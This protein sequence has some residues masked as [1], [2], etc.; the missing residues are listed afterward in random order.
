MGRIKGLFNMSRWMDNGGI[1]SFATGTG[2]AQSTVQTLKVPSS[3][4]ELVAIRGNLLNTAPAVAESMAGVFSISG[5]DSKIGMYEF[6]SEVGGSKLAAINGTPYT[7]EARWWPVNQRVT[8]NSELGF[9]IEML[10]ALAGNG[11]CTVDCL[12]SNIEQP[13]EAFPPINRRCSR[14][15]STASSTGEQITLS[16]ARKITG[17]SFAVAGSTIAAD[18]SFSAQITLN[19][20]NLDITQTVVQNVE[21]HSIE[22]T[23]GQA[24]AYLK[25]VNV[26]LDVS[27]TMESSVTFSAS[28]NEEVALTNAGFWAYAVEYIPTRPKF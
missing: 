14:E 27:A 11:S 9:S 15:T 7:H 28:L 3:A 24:V 20:G 19:S 4:R 13:A 10:D 16:G 17:F 5:K 22:A 2:T 8:P 6:F 25:T 23:S 18:D 26:D 12:W 21:V 1:A